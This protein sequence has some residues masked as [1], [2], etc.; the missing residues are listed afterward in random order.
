M[1]RF[2]SLNFEDKTL[3]FL[4]RLFNVLFCDQDLWYSCW[5]V[6]TAN[7]I[8]CDKYSCQ[9]VSSFQLCQEKFLHIN[10]AYSRVYSHRAIHL[11]KY[12]LMKSP[13]LPFWNLHFTR[14]RI[15]WLLTFFVVTLHQSL[16]NRLCIE[17]FLFFCFIFFIFLMPS[18]LSSLC[19]LHLCAGQTPE[20]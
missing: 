3:T 20:Q 8:A 5:Q 13:L 17:R 1:C 14:C 11:Q 16:L 4:W 15:A 6:S 19:N 18:N 7:A 2:H 10:F 12:V 9:H